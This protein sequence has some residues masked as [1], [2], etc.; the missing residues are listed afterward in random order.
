MMPAVVEV[1]E[2]LLGDV[3]DVAG[4]LFWTELGVPCFDLVLLDVDRGEHVV[5]HET[6]ADRMI[7]SS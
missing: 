7:A 4:D 6:L 3:R 5:L 2:E 1:L